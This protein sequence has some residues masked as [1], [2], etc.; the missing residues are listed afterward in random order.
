MANLFSI[1]I[2]TIFVSNYVL[3]QFLGICPAL[4]VTSKVDTARGMGL[5]VI[6]VIT[7]AS[8]ITWIIQYYILNPLN[9][10]YLQTVVFIL[11]IASLVQA[12]EAVMKKSMPALY[13]ALGVFLPLITTNCVVLGVAI[14]TIDSSYNLV[15]TIVY[16]LAAAVGF[17]IAIT[18]LAYI[19][20]RIEYNS[21]PETF[22]GVPITLVTLGLMAI[23][24]MGFAGLA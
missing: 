7:L 21:L 11:V 14:K 20:E 12:V 24:F 1:I 4:G 15:E 3:G 9:I 17:T 22:K 19:R 13:G 5:A 18:I 6:F 10:E 2:A 8:I 23:A 16:A